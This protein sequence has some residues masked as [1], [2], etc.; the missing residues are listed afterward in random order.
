MTSL[1]GP[2]RVVS[3]AG[4]PPTPQC[5]GMYQGSIYNT[6]DPLQQGRAQLLVPQ[7]LGTAPSN[8]AK[9]LGISTLVTP[10]TVGQYVFTFFIGGDRNQPVYIPQNWAVAAPPANQT[11]TGNLIVDGTTT[12]H[13]TTI[14]SGAT[15]TGGATIDIV[16]G[17]LFVSKPADTSRH[18]TTVS[19]DPDLQLSLVA[20]ATYMVEA[21][22]FN[23][24][25][26]T[27]NMQYQFAI[28]TGATGAC[29]AT[30]YNLSSQLQEIVS[31]PWT[32]NNTVGVN[33]GSMPGDTSI[34]FKGIIVT[35]TTAGTLA[36]QWGQNTS[37]S[38]T[39]VQQFSYMRAERM[40]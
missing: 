15:I 5:F 21:N 18:G 6:N 24:A 40:Q 2:T 31:N 13:G 29:M 1:K 33:T 4:T 26:G 16:N 10:V 11:I 19:S 25:A 39:T 28:P 37:N 9:P 23:T 36:F 22:V 30:Q 34:F 8:W 12:L 32:S 14:S 7:A 17:S 38:T 35:S 20:S 3:S 27:G